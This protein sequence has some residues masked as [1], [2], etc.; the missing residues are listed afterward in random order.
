MDI[1]DY[2]CSRVDNQ[3]DWYDKKSLRN[4]KWYKRI[5]VIEIVIASIIPLLAGYSTSH[6]SIPLIIAIIGIAITIMESISKI[7]QYHE[8]WIEYRS[9]CELLRY[10]KM[11]F[12]TRSFP[13]N[14][15]PETVENLF[16][17]NIEQIIS[18]ENN[19]WKNLNERIEKDKGKKS[20][21]QQDHTT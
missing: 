1:K 12:L 2:I 17:K 20:P 10:Q 13:Y 14:E 9:T 8:N 5:Q 18:A 15:Q 3:I 7:N 6:W 19:Q 16:V 21:S 11:L 4:Q